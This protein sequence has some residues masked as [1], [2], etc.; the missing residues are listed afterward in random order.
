[1]LSPSLAIVLLVVGSGLIAVAVLVWAFVRGWIDA[2]VIDRQK[3]AIFDPEDLR[4]ERPWETPAQRADRIATYG[5][6]L[7]AGWTDT[8]G[9]R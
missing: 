3:T 9:A 1:M 6:P 7:D 8:A 5:P 4:A 2:E